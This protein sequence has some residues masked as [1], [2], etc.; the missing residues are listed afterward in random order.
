MRTQ[1]LERLGALV[2][3]YGWSLQWESNAPISHPEPVAMVQEGDV[4]PRHEQLPQ[5]GPDH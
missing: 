1:G 3:M 5:S 2:P 4:T